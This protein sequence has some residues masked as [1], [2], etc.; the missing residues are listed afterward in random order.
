MK[1]TILLL[2]SLMSALGTMAQYNCTVVSSDRET[3]TYRVTGYGKNVKIAS[4]DA[5]LSAIKVLCFMGAP[6][7]P[8]RLPLVPEGQ[9]T[10]EKEHPDFFEDLYAGAFQKYIET[11]SIVTPFSKDARKRKC[12]TL[13]VRVRVEQLRSNLEGAGIIR[14]FGL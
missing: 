4:T 8:F 5:E 3:V 11:S 7:T 13:D 6:D 2:L 10:A 1:K 12:I 14:K 9:M